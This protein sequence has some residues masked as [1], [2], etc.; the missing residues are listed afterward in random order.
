[1]KAWLIAVLTLI[2]FIL[3]VAIAIAIWHG[4][5]LEKEQEDSEGKPGEK[6]HRHFF[7][8]AGHKIEKVA[9]FAMI[10]GCACTVLGFIELAFEQKRFVI[11]V[12]C[13]VL[14][15]FASVAAGYVLF[16]FGQLV[17]DVHKGR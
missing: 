1:M 10:S 7:T 2:L 11:A 17:D 13:L 9:Y 14:G 15:L 5:Y 16:G 6:A 4:K 12:I 3:A 8:D